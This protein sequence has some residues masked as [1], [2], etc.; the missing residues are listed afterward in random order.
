MIEHLLC[1][2]WYVIDM[3]ACTERYYGALFKGSRGVTQGYLLYPSIFDMVVDAVI[4][5]WVK[6]VTGE[7]PVPYVFGRA[8]QTLAALFYEDYVILASSWMSRI[9]EALNVLTG[10]FDW[11]VLRKNFNKIVG[12]T[13]QSCCTLV[14]QSKVAY[15]CRMMWEG[16]SY[17]SIQQ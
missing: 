11:I 17:R 4:R 1:C 8:V 6:V 12:M 2:Y 13:C 3:V 9:Q 7:R 16:P 5:H 10:L 15:T 14:R